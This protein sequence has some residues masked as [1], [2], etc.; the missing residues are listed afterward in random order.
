MCKSPEQ[1]LCNSVWNL[2]QNVILFLFDLNISALLC[3]IK[4]LKMVIKSRIKEENP[5]KNKSSR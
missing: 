4:V 2:K 5:L 3:L 1:E